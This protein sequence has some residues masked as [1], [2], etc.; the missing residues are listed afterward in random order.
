M[1]KKD[2]T[3]ATQNI[4]TQIK[5]Y[6]RSDEDIL[7]LLAFMER[8][9]K[10]SANNQMMIASQ[11][12]GAI[13][14]GSYN[15]WKKLGYPVKK[16]EKGKIKIFVP[17]TSTT[18]TNGDGKVKSIS[19]ATAQEKALIAEGVLKTIQKLHFKLGTVFD[20]S[21]TN[22]PKDDYPK[23]FPNHH[24]NYETTENTHSLI[25]GLSAYADRI[26]TSILSD[27][28]RTIG[29]AKGAFL[30]SH[31]IIL[32]N[33]EN[34]ETETV[35]VLIH[36]LAHAT[37]HR[38]SKLATLQ[39]EFQAEMVSYLVAKHFGIDTTKQSTKYLAEWTDNLNK[40]ETTVVIRLLEGVQTTTRRI[41]DTIH[42]ERLV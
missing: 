42:T 9:Y 3:Q 2:L 15:Y 38:E 24:I 8:F 39:K 5:A 30:P 33:P 37:L 40:I 18:F 36:E 14:V 32:M 34:T 31:N 25:L 19:K 1:D 12:N 11:W 26:K 20:V 4:I 41:I 6:T 13:A 10:Y 28:N 17:T 27:T 7:E 35:V 16:G 21:Q 22:M 23:L 29:N